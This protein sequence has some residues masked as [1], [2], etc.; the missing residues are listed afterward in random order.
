[1]HREIPVLTEEQKKLFEENT[2][3]VPH[4]AQQYTYLASQ[5]TA[6]CDIEDLYQAGYIGLMHAAAKF[7]PSQ[8]NKFSTY[9]YPCIKYMIINELRDMGTFIPVPYRIAQLAREWDSYEFD[10]LTEKEIFAKH[11]NMD[12]KDTDRLT[13]IA[14]MLD[15]PIDLD[16]L[17]QIDAEEYDSIASCVVDTGRNQELLI[18]HREMCERIQEMLKDLPNRGVPERDISILKDYFGL[19]GP[20]KTQQKIAQ[21]HNLSPSRVGQLIQRRIRQMRNWYRDAKEHLETCEEY[22]L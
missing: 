20:A 17:K 19:E 22:D 11:H 8:G 18:L 1:M 21:E 13:A 5:T 16:E 14:Q 15:Y 2:K 6:A 3:L 7:D 10:N 4:I 9:A 12:I